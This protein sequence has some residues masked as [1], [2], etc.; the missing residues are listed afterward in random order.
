MSFRVGSALDAGK[1]ALSLLFLLL[2]NEGDTHSREKIGP[3]QKEMRDPFV[4]D[5]SS[6]G[7]RQFRSVV[8]NQFV[9]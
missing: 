8:L 3:R 2:L 4:I 7:T 9:A 1:A 6:G 5:L